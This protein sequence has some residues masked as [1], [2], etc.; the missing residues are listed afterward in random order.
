MKVEIADPRTDPEP[1][2]WP[3]FRS[4]MRLHPVWDYR[5]LRL[6]AWTARN[7]PVLAVVRADDGRVIG[8]LSVMVCRSWND[9]SYAPARYARRT[10]LRP[11]WAEVYLPLLSGYPACVLDG[12]AGVRREAIRCFERELVRFLGT[13]LLGVMYRAMTLELA[14]AMSGPA[15]MRRQIDPTAVL[16]GVESEQDWRA[17]VAP[18]V[19]QMLDEFAADPGVRSTAGAARDDLDASELAAL[20]NAHR[21][22]QDERAWAGGQRS[23]IGGLHMDTRSPVSAAYLDE[24]VHRKDIV[25]RTYTTPG[26]RLLGFNTM[27]DHPR[28]AAVH[29]WAAV[30]RAEGGR[31]D[32]YVDAYAHCVRQMLERRSGEL[33]AGRAMLGEKAALGF[34]TRDLFTVA[35]PRPVLGR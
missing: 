28:S 12:D 3:V 8:G 7:P 15:R 5:L 18:R 6:E 21:A 14:D 22:R 27:I 35:A 2:G 29:H 33:T 17:A 19:R 23:R 11:R 16:A 31:P 30:P 32:L 1:E 4:R 13:G 10:R 26:G 24:L 20:L 25:T 9:Q 34:G